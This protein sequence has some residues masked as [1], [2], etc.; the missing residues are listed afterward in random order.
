VQG[1]KWHPFGNEKDEK[2]K[3]RLEKL[4]FT[5]LDWRIDG[6][7]DWAEF[8]LK[9]PSMGEDEQ[10]VYDLIKASP[11]GLCFPEIVEQWGRPINCVTGRVRG[12]VK[13]GWVR[14]SGRTAF[15]GVTNRYVT[16]WETV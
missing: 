10:E 7:E 12:L 6:H 13:K 4:G 3:V 11:G 15:N 14:D 9:R 5:V 2:Q 16:V 8:V 1:H